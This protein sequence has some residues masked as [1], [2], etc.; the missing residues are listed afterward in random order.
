MPQLR[1]TR[2][3]FCGTVA[4]LLVAANQRSGGAEPPAD[5]LPW[6]AEVQ[7]PPGVLPEDAPRLRSLLIDE[8]DRPITSL[9]AWQRRR[10]AIRRQWQQFLGTLDLQREAPPAFRVLDEERVDGT[11]RQ[12]VEY[13]T[14]PGLV[15]EAYLLKPAEMARPA[16]GAVVLHSTVRYTIRQPAGVE[17]DPEKAFGLR[18]ARQGFVVLCP[19]CFLWTRDL[20]IGYQ[21][22]V[23]RF[24]ARHPGARG[25]AKMLHDAQVAVDVLAGMPE[26]DSQRLGAVGHSLGGKEVLYLAAFDQRIGVAVS[27]EGGIGTRFCNWHAPWYLGPE[28]LEPDFPHEHHEL[29]ALVAPRAFLLIGGDASDGDRSWPFIQAARE[30]Y[31]L[32]PGTARLGLFNHRQGHSVPP[33][34]ERHIDQWMLAYGMP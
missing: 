28:I 15:V 24:R 18:L 7:Q 14:E 12:L 19:R 21:E 22:H 4:G 23:R 16:P 27:S 34:A 29:L 17:G 26:V 3:R 9:A 25:M 30:V 2:R 13:E 11:I 8:R 5:Q 20:S 6:L 1:L 33:E 32:Y 31:D 10:E